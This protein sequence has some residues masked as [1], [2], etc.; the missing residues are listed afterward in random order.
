MLADEHPGD[1][2]QLEAAALRQLQQFH[3]HEENGEGQDFTSVQVLLYS[4]RKFGP[5]GIRQL[6][7]C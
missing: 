2:L 6:V 7:V 5:E 1:A 4:S 3:I